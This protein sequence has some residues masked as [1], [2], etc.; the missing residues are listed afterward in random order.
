MN[1]TYI[2]LWV[3][4]KSV[5]IS[6]TQI[7]KRNYQ[8]LGQNSC[9]SQNKTLTSLSSTWTKLVLISFF[10][11]KGTKVHT[12]YHSS[13]SSQVLFH[14]IHTLSSLFC[15]YNFLHFSLFFIRFHLAW[16][17]CFHL[18]KILGFRVFIWHD[19]RVFCVISTWISVI[20]IYLSYHTCS[21]YV[22]SS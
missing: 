10:I 11:L 13:Y 5:V 18:A 19:F 14:V 4:L 8:A 20:G 7:Y 12:L 16:F 3:S 6:F 2:L 15:M 9:H 21:M 17:S 1:S 22:M